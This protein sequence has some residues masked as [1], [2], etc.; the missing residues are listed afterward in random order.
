MMEEQGDGCGTIA[1]VC[2]EVQSVSFVGSANETAILTP[3]VTYKTHTL[4]LRRRPGVVRDGRRWWVLKGRN[5]SRERVPGED[6]K[7]SSLSAVIG[8]EDKQ[9]RQARNGINR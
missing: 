3:C 5:S 8:P 1:Q 7:L 4:Y 2:T 6:R 9:E